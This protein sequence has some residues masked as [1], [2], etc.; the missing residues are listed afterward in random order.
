MAYGID[1]ETRH[2][3]IGLD[4]TIDAKVK[5]K[6][7]VFWSSWWSLEIPCGV[8][9]VELSDST[10]ESGNLIAGAKPCREGMWL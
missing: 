1:M 8:L 9:E 2:G 4:L 7:G 5:F 10:G 6:P 3:K